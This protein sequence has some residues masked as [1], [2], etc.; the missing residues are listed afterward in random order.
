MARLAPAALEPEQAVPD[1]EWLDDVE[2][3]AWRQQAGP[4]PLDVEA[5]VAATRTSQQHVF[6]SVVRSRPADLKRTT[7]GGFLEEDMGITLHALTQACRAEMCVWVE[8]TPYNFKSAISEA[9]GTS[10]LGLLLLPSK[11]PLEGLE[12][13]RAWHVSAD[14]LKLSFESS[15][16]IPADVGEAACKQVLEEILRAPGGLE[17][18]SLCSELQ[19]SADVILAHWMRLGLVQQSGGPH[20]SV[21][22][23]TEVGLQGVRASI[24]LDSSKLLLAR[25]PSSAN[26]DFSCSMY[27]LLLHLDDA[28]WT[29]TVAATRR[30]RREA[31][32]TLSHMI[33][34][35]KLGMLN[36][37]RSWTQHYSC[38]AELS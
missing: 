18:S 22:T 11:I 26:H 5:L 9:A 28:G 21:W 3:V 35:R 33:T 17:I 29:C 27:H 34:Q 32:R 8:R 30:A 6:F 31:R 24:K 15:G 38:I 19:D 37:T 10:A 25:C 16:A 12:K 4:R 7:L 13:V 20:R 23:L 14:A 36:L 2:G 1:A